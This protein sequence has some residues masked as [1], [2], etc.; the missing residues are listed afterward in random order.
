M[1]TF[2]GRRALQNGPYGG[3]WSTFRTAGGALSCFLVMDGLLGC[4][5]C[6]CHS[7]MENVFCSGGSEFLG[8]M[9]ICSLRRV[10]RV[11][12]AF[13]DALTGRA[14]LDGPW[15]DPGWTLDTGFALD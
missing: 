11:R 3:R 8:L 7:H 2:P 13:L 12:S 6:A 4:R 14:G 5:I 9:K 15:M 1:S 10:T